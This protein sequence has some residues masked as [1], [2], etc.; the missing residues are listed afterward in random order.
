M[1]LSGSTGVD[2]GAIYGF[3]NGNSIKLSLYMKKMIHQMKMIKYLETENKLGKNI[4]VK[5]Y[6]TY[7]PRRDDH[8]MTHVNLGIMTF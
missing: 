3:S 1:T 7:Q 4:I 2:T 8:K 5:H 6:D